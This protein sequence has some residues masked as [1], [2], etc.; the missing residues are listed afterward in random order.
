IDN[1][2]MGSSSNR[3][4]SFL[5]QPI[6]TEIT[7]MDQVDTFDEGINKSEKLYSRIK[8]SSEFHNSLISAYLNNNTNL[9]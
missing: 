9:F 8:E 1:Q 5:L 3:I 7:E 6:I 2:I 4:S